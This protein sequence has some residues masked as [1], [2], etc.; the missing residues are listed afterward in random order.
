MRNDVDLAAR[1]EYTSRR[2]CAACSLHP[3]QAIGKACDSRDNALIRLGSRSTVWSVV[4]TASLIARQGKIAGP[5]HPINAVFMLHADQVVSLKLENS[6]ARFIR[7]QI[8][9]LKFK[10]HF[11]RVIVGR[12]RVIYG[13]ER[14]D[15][16][17]TP[18]RHSQ[19]RSKRGD[20]HCVAGSSRKRDTRRQGKT[21][22]H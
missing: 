7:G 15:R 19:V 2:N 18:R 11:L 14:A 10:S 4:T 16:C 21:P 1:T 20:A 9:L 3:R 5:Q 22:N 6:A 8:F 17:Q 13:I 12:F